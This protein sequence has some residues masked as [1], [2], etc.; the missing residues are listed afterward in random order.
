MCFLIICGIKNQRN[1]V[2]KKK[3]E[4]KIDNV[5]PICEKSRKL[6]AT[7]FHHDATAWLT[8]DESFFMSTAQ[9]HHPSLMVECCMHIRWM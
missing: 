1:D 5:Q 7:N 2:E 4:T 9:N 3:K 8:S 6:Y